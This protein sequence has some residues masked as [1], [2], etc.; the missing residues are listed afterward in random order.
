MWRVHANDCTT[1]WYAYVREVLALLCP[2][3]KRRKRKGWVSVEAYQLVLLRSSTRRGA[4][5]ERLEQGQACEATLQAYAVAKQAARRA[6]RADNKYRD[7][8]V[9][10][11]LRDVREKGDHRQVFELARLLQPY[12]RAVP[13]SGK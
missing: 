11:Q 2:R 12:K 4:E 3:S 13:R 6:P 1:V 10:A 7:C 8:E 5:K 9:A